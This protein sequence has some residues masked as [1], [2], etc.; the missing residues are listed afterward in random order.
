MSN[1]YNSNSWNT[2]KQRHFTGFFFPPRLL[3]NKVVFIGIVV[4]LYARHCFYHKLIT[5]RKITITIGCS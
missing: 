2:R 5:N 3:E 4:F 1:T